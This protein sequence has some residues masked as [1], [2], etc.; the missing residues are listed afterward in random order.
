MDKDEMEDLKSKIPKD[1]PVLEE[2]P[3]LEKDDYY[4]NE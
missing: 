2:T 1:K 3:V 4:M